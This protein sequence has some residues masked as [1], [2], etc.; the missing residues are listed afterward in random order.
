VA[1]V[2]GATN[3]VPGDA[4]KKKD[5]F[6]HGRLTGETTRVSV[7]SGGQGANADSAAPVLSADGRFVAFESAAAC[8]SSVR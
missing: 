7:S 2:S 3:L 1:F 6:V 8:G 5:I 4:N